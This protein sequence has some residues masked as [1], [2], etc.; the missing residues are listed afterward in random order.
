MTRSK[1]PK[2]FC[3]ANSSQLTAGEC[4]TQDA[5]ARA[6]THA[7]TECC[8]ETGSG[9]DKV[10][11][12]FPVGGKKGKKRRRR[13]RKE[14]RSQF[15]LPPPQKKERGDAD[16]MLAPSTKQNCRFAISAASS[17]KT[18]NEHQESEAARRVAVTS[19]ARLARRRSTRPSATLSNGGEREVDV[20]SRGQTL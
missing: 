14:G 10:S 7:H 5:D 17:A 20:P 3:D 2:R 8:V 13:R 12:V 16:E 19:G 6:R 15:E 11:L 18:S 4:V 1:V 9:P